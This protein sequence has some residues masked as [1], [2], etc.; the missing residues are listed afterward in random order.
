MGDLLQLPRR[1]GAREPHY[2][3]VSRGTFAG[4]LAGGYV[5]VVVLMV[6]IMA[7]LPPG[8]TFLPMMAIVVGALGLAVGRR[9]WLLAHVRRNDDAVALLNRGEIAPAT[10][11]LEDLTRKTRSAPVYHGLF[12]YN[13]GVTMLRVGRPEQALS[14]FTNVLEAGWL[15]SRRASFRGM[16][17]A[18]MAAAWAQ[19]GELG[20]AHAWLAEAHGQIGDARRGMLLPTDVIVALRSGRPEQALDMLDAGWNAAEGVLTAYQ[21]RTVHLLRAFALTQVAPTAER[22]AAY[23]AAL[24]SATPKRP[25]DYVGIAAHWPEM[26]AFLRE[27]SWLP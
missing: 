18:G 16:I 23:Q 11:M 2:R 10:H 12:V 7:M 26:T 3:P 8:A 25:E 6:A 19:L 20:A 14:L 21:M 17:S 1:P 13:R 9:Q 15:N 24:A 27:R 5:G 4:L 22:H